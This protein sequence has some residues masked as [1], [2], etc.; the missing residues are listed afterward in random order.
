MSKTVLLLIDLQ[1]DFLERDG[2]LPVPPACAERVI[3]V[4]N[5]M[6]EH[7]QKSGW[8]M[9]WVKNEFRWWQLAGNCS[10]RFAAMKGS[11]GAEIDPRIHCTTDMPMVIKC[12]ADAFSNPRMATVLKEAAPERVII[13]GLMTD[14]CVQETARGAISRGYRVEVVED[15]VAAMDDTDHQKGLAN[16]R[17][18]GAQLRLSKDILGETA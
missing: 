6:I 18:G 1:R 8:T 7:A 16:M 9:I 2:R 15:D 11:R 4:A 5:D 14:E 3:G 17:E 10:R 12:D 13:L